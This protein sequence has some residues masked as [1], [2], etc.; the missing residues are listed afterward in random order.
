M[1]KIRLPLAKAIVGGMI[2][3][4]AIPPAVYWGWDY[5]YAA[6]TSSSLRSVSEMTS[7]LTGAMTNRRETIT[8]TF[9]GKTAN[10]KAQLQ[11]AVDQAMA[12]DP[13]LYYIVD[14]YG[15]SYRG[16]TRSAKVT[17]QVKYRETLEQTA[18]VNKRVKAAVKQ[19]TTPGMNPHQKVK[20]IH[21]WVVRQLKYDTSYRKYTAYEALQTGSAVCQGYS[22]LTYKLLLE[23]G[24][25]NKIVEGTAKPEGGR[26]QSHA[27]NLVLL[28]GRWYHLDT[29]WDDPLPDKAGAVSTSYYMRTDAQL[30]RDHTWVKSYPATS[31]SYAQTLSGLVKKGGK[32]TAVYRKLQTELDY[33]LYE[34]EQMVS[35][36]AGMVKLAEIAAAKGEQSILF[37][38][39]GSTRQLEKDLQ[40]LYTL[41]LNKLS[42]SSAPF[43]NTSDL[44]VFVTWK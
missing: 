14:S 37:R 41:G 36:A 10:L 20:A 6:A 39:R 26:S 21:D 35:S 25:P 34:E 13:Y 11:K 44:K 4:A 19:M 3:A 27:W 31:V 2:I 18:F 23:A 15:Y 29:T 12:S 43:D 22:L 9:E 32:D 1:R 28:D 40:G 16:S 38:Y 33:G 17:I 30:R 7:R 8:F 42:Y 5:A 24:I